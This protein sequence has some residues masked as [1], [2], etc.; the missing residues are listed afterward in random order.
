MV[1]VIIGFFLFK[2]KRLVSEQQKLT[3]PVCKDCNIIFVSF[4]T[5]RASNIHILGYEKD[6]TP[7]LDKFAQKGFIFT[8]A[9]SVSSWTLPASMSWFTGAYPSKHKVL[10]KF[11]VNTKGEEEI[12]NL[13][14][15]SPDLTTLAEVLKEKGYKTG[16][17]TGGAAL[18]SQFGFDKGFDE[19]YDDINFGG[20]KDTIPGALAFVNKHKNEK[21]F[22]F[23]HGYD[24]HGQYVPEGGYDR[25]F[26]DFEYKGNLT[27]SKEEQKILREEGVNTGRIFL[28]KDDVKFLTALYDEKIQRADENFAHFLE[29]Y[30]KLNL[31]DKTIFVITSDHGEELYEHGR[32]DH[33]HSLYDELVR[34]P[35]FIII[36]GLKVG[37]IKIYEQV[38]SIDIMPTLFELSGIDFPPEVKTQIQGQGLSALMSGKAVHLDIYPE[39]DYR[40]T[41]RLRAIRSWDSYKVIINLDSGREEFFNLAPDPK[42]TND[43]GDQKSERLEEVTLMLKNYLKI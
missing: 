2:N 1:L 9:V 18:D 30:Q 29:D 13:E 19:Y 4:D 5:L 36:P 16:A 42:E 3:V 8:N 20:F 40:Y 27:G 26:V 6:T 22:L 37:G 32:I 21:F 43:L 34:V 35:L 10:N 12:T 28:T 38:R 25:R 17:F 31:L 41:E 39:T 23:L 33:G 7:F 24:I 11:T 15:V 14:K